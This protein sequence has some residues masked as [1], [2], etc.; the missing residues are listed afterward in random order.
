MNQ[1]VKNLSGRY[2]VMGHPIAHSLS[3]WIHRAFAQQTRQVIQYEAIDVPLTDFSAVLN[4]FVL[5][6]GRGANVTLP[7]KEQAFALMDACSERAALA[8]SVNTIVVNGL[9]H[10]FGDNTDGIGLIRDFQRLGVVISGGRWLILGAGGATRGILPVLLQQQPQEIVLANRTREKA[11]QL[12]HEYAT[13][14]EIHAIDFGDLTHQKPFS[15]IVHATSAGLTGQ[16]LQLP[17]TLLSSQTFCYDLMYA[18]K[19]TPFLDWA[20]THLAEHT[21]DGLGM[22]VEQAAESF[23]VWTSVHPDTLQVLVALRQ[24]LQG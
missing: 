24:H 20:R 8:R 4:D 2:A 3:P 22:L 16:F 12:A 19:P 17:S 6:E 15:G 7:F 21:S 14:G 5:H 18:A 23:F 1:S 13:L 10:Y 11:A 9:G